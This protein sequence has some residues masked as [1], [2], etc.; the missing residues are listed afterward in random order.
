MER[1]LGKLLGCAAVLL[2]LVS[3]KGEAAAADFYRGKTVTIV[4]SSAVGGGYD[5]LSRVLGRHIGRHIPG[6]PTIVINNMPGAGGIAATNYL[7]NNALKDGTVIGGVQNNTPLEP[8]LGT[9]QARYDPTKFN[10]LGSPSVEI[11]LVVVWNT[12]PV[13]TVADLQQREVVMGSTGANSTPSFYARLLNETLGT[14]MKLIVGY[15]GQNESFIA[16]E[17]GE[18]DG[19]PSMFYSSMMAT[20]PDL[21]REKKVKLLLQYGPFKEPALPDVPFVMDL[22]KDPADRAVLEAGFAALALGRPYLMPPGVPADRVAIMR[23]ALAET[24]VDLQ[25]RA[26]ATRIGMT[27]NQPRSGEQLQQIIAQ[28]YRT[29]PAVIARLRQLAA[30]P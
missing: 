2:A 8:L 15:P 22:E 9:T 6:N 29:P 17:R 16:M 20:Q 13:N 21:L 24:F 12:V 10:W 1:M 5:A 30:A 7:Y 23:K 18:L 26:E 25:F 27:P 14:K 28:T 4:V 19:H 3:P 11:G